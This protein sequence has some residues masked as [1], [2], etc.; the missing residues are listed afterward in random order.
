MSGLSKH[1]HQKKK[2]HEQTNIEKQDLK[3]NGCFLFVCLLGFVWLKYSGL[4]GVG[5]VALDIK[6]GNRFSLATF[7]GTCRGGQ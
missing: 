4:K 3:K 2:N 6:K 5:C 7:K 1:S